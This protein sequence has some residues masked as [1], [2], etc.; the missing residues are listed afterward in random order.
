MQVEYE[1]LIKEA[2]MVVQESE[3]QYHHLV[4][5]IESEK[6][7]KVK[8]LLQIFLRLE[9]FFT[10]KDALQVEIS[11]L[12]EKLENTISQMS[13]DHENEVFD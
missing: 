6:R 9:I 12:E 7:S 10:F 4:E 2:K 5:S 3:R 13:R 1:Q 11:V 8:F